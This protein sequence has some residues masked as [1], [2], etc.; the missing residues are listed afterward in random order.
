M[1]CGYP[2]KIFHGEVN[3]KFLCGI[4]GGVLKE[5]IQGSCG[6]R[7]CKECFVKAPK[8]DMC[9]SCENS[10]E[11]EKMFYAEDSAFPDNAIKRELLHQ[12]VKCCN[13]NCDWEG[14]FKNFETHYHICDHSM[15]DCDVCNKA[16]GRRKMELHKLAHIM[17]DFGCSVDGSEEVEIS[18]TVEA[19]KQIALDKHMNM[20]V[21]EHMKIIHKKV[22]QLSEMYGIR[23]ADLVDLKKTM[24]EHIESLTEEIERLKKEIE[25]HKCDAMPSLSSEE[26]AIGG[27]PPSLPHPPPIQTL[28]CKL[29]I[30][31]GVLTVLN[32]EIE[33]L[34]A[35]VETSEHRTRG[36]RDRI[37]GL[38][39]RIA[40]M[41]CKCKAKDALIA[42]QALSIVRL[43]T[44]DYTGQ[45]TWRISNITKC[46][47]E[48]ISGKTPSIYST[49]FYTS[50]TGYKMCSRIYLNGDGMGKGTHL[51]L[52]FIMMRG[53]YDALL[54]WPFSQ[55]ITFHL[56]DQNNKD[57]VFDA[58]RPDPTSSS[59]KRPVTDMNIAS[60]CPMLLPLT[61]L[62]NPAHGYIKDNTMFIK[63]I[64]SVDDLV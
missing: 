27:A 9:K 25:R 55:K 21:P 32:M 56:V 44:T 41:E 54:K 58:F 24:T 2:T 14:S 51:S 20:Q 22:L 15:M 10:E 59:F 48:A 36:D 13:D 39:R 50:K 19:A 49:P 53:N 57:H 45:L 62:D 18:D 52:F 16:V 43:E 63:I 4:C 60:G 3:P 42:E 26:G 47:Q 38:E 11:E 5:P 8:G 29:N 23:T 40:S 28:N 37:E 34:T 1:D 33:K 17:C 12:N 61:M 46:R 6:H 64:V 35:Q 7:Y 30:Y 31:E